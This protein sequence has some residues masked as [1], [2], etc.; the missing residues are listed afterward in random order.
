MAI[1]IFSSKLKNNMNNSIFKYLILFV[2]ITL[3]LLIFIKLLPLLLLLIAA[4]SVIFLIY[5]LN[6]VNSG[7]KTVDDLKQ[8]VV[9]EF[10]KILTYIK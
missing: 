10:K 4:A 5:G 3:G 6:E 2:V 8:L 1:S 7:R 9:T